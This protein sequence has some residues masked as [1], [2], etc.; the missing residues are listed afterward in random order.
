MSFSVKVSSDGVK[1]GPLVAVLTQ[2]HR[3]K[4]F[5]GDERLYFSIHAS[6][7]KAG[8][9][10]AIVPMSCIGNDFQMTG[11]IFD[12]HNRQWVQAPVGKPDV[13]YNRIPYRKQEKLESFLRVKEAAA[14]DN[15]PFLNPGF[16]SKKRIWRLLS[17]DKELAH[18]LPDTEELSSF[19]QLINWVNRHPQSLIKDSSGSKGEGIYRLAAENEHSYLLSAQTKIT[20][21]LSIE[22][23]WKLLRP[24]LIKRTLLLQEQIDLTH[25]NGRPYDFRVL[26]HKIKNIW[27]C[28]GA[29][30]R[31]AGDNRY[32]THSLY[33]GSLL[34]PVEMEIDTQPVQ[35]LAK[36]T[37]SLLPDSF[38]EVSM[39]IGC[40]TAGQLY[41]FDINS[42]PM[43]FDEPSI[44]KAGAE[45]LVRIFHELTRFS[46]PL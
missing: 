31:A 17:A 28:S 14:R 3:V 25:W 27:E 42:K 34:D 35:N 46:Q 22:S 12:P 44:Q 26:L 2:S 4:P 9:V 45:N 21:P 7:Q 16:L 43:V 1:A 18:S 10:L 32:T 30:I 15:I 40:S 36:H 6:L 11:F 33:G 39:D 20:P 19:K 23:V 8:G 37:A 29:G 5:T 24:L 41:V 38:F 13:I